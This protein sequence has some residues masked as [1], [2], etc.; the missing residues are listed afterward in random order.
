MMKYGITEL[1]LLFQNDVR[2]LRD[3]AASD[4]LFMDAG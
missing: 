3:E 4:A 2:F 1:P